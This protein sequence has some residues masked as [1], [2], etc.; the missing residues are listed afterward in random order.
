[1][2]D[3]LPNH[4]LDSSID[5][6]FA[7]DHQCRFTL[8]N[9]ALERFFAID[10]VHSLG[11]SV[12][13]V[14][15]FLLNR[16]EEKH[17]YKA[18]QGLT[19]N[20]LNVSFVEGSTKQQRWFNGHYSPVKDWQGN[21]LGGLGIIRDITSLHYKEIEWNRLVA[22]QLDRKRRMKTLSKEELKFF[23]RLSQGMD[24]NALAS[25]FDLGLRSVVRMKKRI[26]DKLALQD[27]NVY[28]LYE[29][30]TFKPSQEK[31]T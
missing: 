31:E 7:F 28:S 1:M 20:S 10:Q 13:E 27:M 8:I 21:I 9:R 29:H 5:G 11:K 16:G 15:P 14:L 26:R 24:N 3:Q 23:K 12:F 22:Q 18:L 19:V 6:I 30:C 17:F 4:L 25:E 2:E